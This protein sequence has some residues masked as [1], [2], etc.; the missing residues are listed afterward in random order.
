MEKKN[1]VKIK[2]KIKFKNLKTN[3]KSYIKEIS[4]QLKKFSQLYKINKI[5]LLKETKIYKN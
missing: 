4:K 2:Y 3:L 1:K 5:L